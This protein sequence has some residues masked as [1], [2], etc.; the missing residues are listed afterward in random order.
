MIAP[1]ALFRAVAQPTMRSALCGHP[2]R[3]G[4]CAICAHNRASAGLRFGAEFPV[5]KIDPKSSAT[6]HPHLFN[7]HKKFKERCVSEDTLQ[8]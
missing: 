7:S 6:P 5:K 2:D 1:L 8:R 4:L 3:A